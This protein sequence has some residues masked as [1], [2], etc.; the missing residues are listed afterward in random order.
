VVIKN[1]YKKFEFIKPR[2]HVQLSKRFYII[3]NV[4]ALSI[5][6]IICSSDCYSMLALMFD[7]KTVLL[8]C[9]MNVLRTIRFLYAGVPACQLQS[10]H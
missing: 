8:L 7:Y 9:V 1:S 6:Y 3:V 5:E 2:F 4:T 10:A